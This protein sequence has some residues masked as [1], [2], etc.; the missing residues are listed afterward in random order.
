MSSSDSKSP[1]KLSLAER[2][3]ETVAQ[4]GEIFQRQKTSHALI[5]GIA[6]SVRSRTRTTKDVDLLLGVPQLELPGLLQA[7]LDHGCQFDLVAAIREWNAGGMLALVWSNGVRVDLLKPVIPSFQHIL[8]RASEERIG[9]QIIRV[10]D[11]EGLLLL[12]LIAFRPIDQDDIHAILVTNSGKLDLDWVR[13]EARQSG[14]SPERLAQFEAMVE[15]FSD[16][17]SA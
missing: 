1:L 15:E 3:T 17:P 5:G 14:T 10:A 16:P 6:A 13:D 9:G 12:K 4:L 2:L 8:N 7:M 11:A